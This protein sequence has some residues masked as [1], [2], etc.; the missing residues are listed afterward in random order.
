MTEFESV[1]HPMSYGI[2]IDI[3]TVNETR[4]SIDYHRFL[5]FDDAM[6]RYTLKREIRIWLRKIG[7]LNWEHG[8]SPSKTTWNQY[9]IAFEQEHDLTLFLLRW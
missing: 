4:H 2:V 7:I 9:Y 8:Y 5:E 3:Y 1:N 6:A